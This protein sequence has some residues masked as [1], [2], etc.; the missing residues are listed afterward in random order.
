MIKNYQDYNDTVYTYIFIYSFLENMG[1]I[2][3]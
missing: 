1:L 3:A 2:V